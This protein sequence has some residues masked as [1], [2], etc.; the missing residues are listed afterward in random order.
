MNKRIAVRILKRRYMSNEDPY[1]GLVGTVEYGEYLC[2]RYSP[3]EI[4]IN[5]RLSD[6]SSRK[7]REYNIENGTHFNPIFSMIIFQN[8]KIFTQIMDNE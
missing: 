3:N 7:V 8:L 6:S 5:V 2:S 1:Y 4:N